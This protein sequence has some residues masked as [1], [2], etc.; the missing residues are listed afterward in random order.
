M[1]MDDELD[2]MPPDHAP[3]G[4]EAVADVDDTL[5]RMVARTRQ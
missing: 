1:E 3:D 4:A 5:L 2:A